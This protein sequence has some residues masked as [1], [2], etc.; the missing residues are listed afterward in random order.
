MRSAGAGSRYRGPTA[1]A[2]LVGRALD[3]LTARRG[4]ATAELI[5]GWAEIVG[6]RYADC[7]RP[8][9]IVWSR[10]AANKDQPGTLVVAVEG[11]RAL[12]LQHEADQIVERV[13]S[14]LGHGAVGR[15]KIV[16]GAVS[17][18]PTVEAP[19]EP[20]LTVGDLATLGDVLA[21]VDD[22]NLRSALDRLGRAIVS[23]RN[24]KT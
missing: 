2:E 14:F 10:G 8:E 22:A 17:S 24:K 12:L 15:I 23:E 7:S 19:D 5:A 11:P 6:V 9:R 4:F 3:P 13:N 21:E 16:Q 18:R 20:S 1:L